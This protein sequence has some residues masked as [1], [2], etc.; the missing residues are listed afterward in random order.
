MAKEHR[1]SIDRVKQRTQSATAKRPQRLT[2]RGSGITHAHQQGLHCVTRLGGV[3]QEQV[4]R[5]LA[6]DWPTS[7]IQ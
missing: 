6:R 3:A 1:K 5:G 4:H 2:K 7:A